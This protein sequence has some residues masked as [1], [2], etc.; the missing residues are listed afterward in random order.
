MSLWVDKYKPQ[1]ISDIVGNKLQIKKARLWLSNY[2][3]K[4]KGTKLS[5]FICGPPGI[6]KT[7]LSH[8][9]FKSFNYDVIEFNASDIRNQKLVRE[10]LKSI[11]GKVSISKLMGGN[12]LNGII[13]DEVDGLSSGDKG[14]ISELITF[15]N[16]NKNKRGKNKVEFEYNNPIICISN[17]DSDKKMRDL[18][19]ECE[20]INFVYPKKNELYDYAIKILEKENKHIDDEEL[21]KIVMFCQNDI[22]KLI[23]T[24]EYYFKKPSDSNKNENN[25]SNFLDNLDEKHQDISLFG[26]V[27]NILN[28]YKNIDE[29]INIYLSD[30]NLMNLLIH[31][32]ILGIMK[33][34]KNNE[35]DK[36]K[37]MEKI[38]ENMAL[39]DIFD[40]EIYMNNNFDLAMV[41]GVIKCASVSYILN[42]QK[43][44]TY[45]KFSSN[46]VIFSKLLSK[47][48]LHYTNHKNR[49]LIFN[50]LKLYNTIDDNFVLLFSIIKSFINFYNTKGEI[51]K[52]YFDIK[53]YVKNYN[54]ESDDF[55]KMYKLIK[56]KIKNTKYEDLLSKLTS[57]QLDKKF[58]Q[59]GLKYI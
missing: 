27:Y 22:R 41:N 21:L 6:G 15:I 9:I 14:G 8:L 57:Q 37:V 30:K 59:K 47:F 17:H 38:Y 11:I 43:K 32:N 39:S 52:N 55:E 5:L 40:N 18:K 49:I 44:L 10:N 29:I 36:I 51:N 53:Y 48:S 20:I 46:D 34:Y 26:S 35:E 12:L 54:L 7:T 16:P 50:K 42:Q 31:E 3:N 2:M 1:K 19:K 13:M 23:S 4:V 25:V 24:L 56:Q 58:F 33:N 45:Q 28:E